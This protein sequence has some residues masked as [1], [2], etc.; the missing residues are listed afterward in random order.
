VRSRAVLAILA[1]L[2]TSPAVAY[3]RTL[4]NGTG[5]PLAWPV[6][7]VPWQLD[8]AWPDTAISCDATAAGDPTLDAVRASF[9][10]WEQSCANLRLPYAGEVSDQATGL[11][12]AGEN[13]VVFRRG[14]CS[15]NPAIVDPATHQILDPCFN[16]P[17]L[18][19]GAKYGCFQDSPR[20]ITQ[21]PCD[22]WKIVALTQVLHDPASGRILAA[23]IQLNG[24]DGSGRGTAMTTS[25]H[26]W[27]FT[28]IPATTQPSG[29]TT[30]GQAGCAGVDL[31][32]TVTHEAGHFVGLAHPCR[33]DAVSG[34]PSLPLCSAP[35]PAGQVP[36]NQRTM[37]PTTQA[38][39]TGKRDLSA[40][41]IAGVCA[42]YP[43]PSGGC[44]CGGGEG[45]GAASLLV[46]ALA[47][48][49]RRRRP[50]RGGDQE[51]T[52]PA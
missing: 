37:S 10:Q 22:D 9:A 32:N 52:S 15:Q 47:L 23:D 31:Q 48:R 21:V 24:W 16:D 36:Y 25:Q 26:G 44:G 7:V 41:D 27:Y 20:C 43:T 39:D 33:A 6:P 11:G 50:R 19:C 4:A 2:W 42:V 46:A 38:G 40:D 3:V 28:C 5:V 45:I 34:D 18:T 12:A 8:R 51:T 17:E 49:R 30:Y 14:W 29:C 35:V 1:L 13:V